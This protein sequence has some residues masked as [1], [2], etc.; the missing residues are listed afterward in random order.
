MQTETNSDRCRMA[1]TTEMPRTEASRSAAGRRPDPCDPWSWSGQ[2][3]RYSV[4]ARNRCEEREIPEIVY[5]PTESR[6]ADVDL[7]DDQVEAVTFKVLCGDDSFFMV[8][9]TDG[10]VV[11]VYR[12][13]QAFKTSQ[14]CK[15]RRRNLLARAA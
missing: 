1:L 3:L 14:H 6:L 15:Q 13:D 8:L 12:K 9:S 10:C 7:S 11:T 5:L 2:P 4:H